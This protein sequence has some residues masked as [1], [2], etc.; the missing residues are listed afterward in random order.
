MPA[1]SF[2][3]ETTARTPGAAARPRR[4]GAALLAAAYIAAGFVQAAQ[5][6]NIAITARRCDYGP[7]AGAGLGRP[8]HRS[9]SNC[10]LYSSAASIEAII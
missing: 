1:P 6:H 2:D 3:D 7:G 5:Q 8:F 9:I 4:R 10:G